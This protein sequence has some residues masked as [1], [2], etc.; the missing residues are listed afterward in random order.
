[1]IKI[2]DNEK[3]K[4]AGWMYTLCFLIIPANE[5]LYRPGIN[6]CLWLKEHL[7]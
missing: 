4:Y 2:N 1:M 7:F 3:D 6:V 5:S